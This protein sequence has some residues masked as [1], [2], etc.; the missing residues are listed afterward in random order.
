[1][2][3]NRKNNRALNI[4]FASALFVLAGITCPTDVLAQRTGILRAVQAAT[5]GQ[6]EESMARRPNDQVEGTVWEYRS[7]EYKMRLEPGE[8]APQIDGRIRIEGNAVF[9]ASPNINIA[10]RQ[11]RAELIQR[12]ARGE[13]VEISAPTGPEEKRIGEYRRLDN[14]KV[15]FE[16]NDPESLNGVM[17]A[18]PKEDAPGV[19]LANYYQHEGEKTTGKW[20]LE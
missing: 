19:W 1:M 11:E 13:G 8:V 2:N 14:G 10:P 12:F 18:W 16:F 3:N 20:L 4:T 17:I 5:Q 15:R 7:I 6:Q 9:D